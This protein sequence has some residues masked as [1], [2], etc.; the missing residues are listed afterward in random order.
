MNKNKKASK[1][2]KTKK[3]KH[4]AHLPYFLLQPISPT[5]RVKSRDKA[6]QDIG[7]IINHQMTSFISLLY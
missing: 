5:P 4:I 6:T 7:R 1:K 2:K 3:K